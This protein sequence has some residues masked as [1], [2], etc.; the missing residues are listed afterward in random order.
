MTRI[1]ALATAALLMASTP[2]VAQ[3]QQDKTYTLTLTGAEVATIAGV[4]NEAPYK[5]AQ[6]ILEKLI[7]QT[8]PP[9]PEPPKDGAK[10]P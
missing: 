7:A 1:A 6:P 8:K 10:K 3:L 4:L 9:T 2:T 5:I